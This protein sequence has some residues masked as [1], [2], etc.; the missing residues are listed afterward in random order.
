MTP[1]GPDW[2]KR[3]KELGLSRTRR[4][5]GEA[6]APGPSTRE[7]GLTGEDLAAR[8][9]A[10]HGLDLLARNVRYADG[11][12]DIVGSARGTLVVVEVKWRRGKE[13]GSAA[14]AVTPKKRRRIVLAAR[15]WLAENQTRRERN[16]R[17]DVVAIQEQPFEIE[18]IRGAFDANS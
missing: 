4:A 7:A 9:L 8:F 5:R 18:W 11:E 1:E 15:R 6:P 3:L 17:F 13:R 16:V 14:E 2:K 10:G 12:L